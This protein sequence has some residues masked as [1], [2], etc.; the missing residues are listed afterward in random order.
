[1]FLKKKPKFTYPA[2]CGVAFNLFQYAIPNIENIHRFYFTL[3][4]LVICILFY[5]FRLEYYSRWAEKN[6]IKLNNTIQDNEEKFSS[7]SKKHENL[8]FRYKKQEKHIDTYDDVSFNFI[9][10]LSILISSCDGEKKD[11]FQNALQMY[12]QMKNE[13]L[14]QFDRKEVNYEE[15]SNN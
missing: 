11:A 15:N 8:K 4:S 7:L 13:K 1:M 10:S 3:L 6:I 2:L 12:L 9:K 14:Q 5:L